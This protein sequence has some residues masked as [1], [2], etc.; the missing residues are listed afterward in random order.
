MAGI[1]KAGAIRE[2][3]VDAPVAAFNL[4]DF[5][6]KADRY[7]EQIRGEA[8]KILQ[9]A[10]AEAQ[11]IRAKAKE[12]GRQQARQ[13]AEKA[14]EAELQRRSETA[15]AT[16]TKVTE[17][18]AAERAQWRQDWET[19][20]VKLARGIAE[21]VIRRELREDPQISLEW[22]REALEMCSRDTQVRIRV[23]LD[24]ARALEPM[25]QALLEKLGR[26]ATTT[27]VPDET[28]PPGEVLLETEHGSLDQRVASQLDRLE[29]ELL[30]E[31]GAA[32]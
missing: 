29:R 5:T 7:L 3:R 32:S 14:L 22:V 17:R 25:L 27:I 1:I 10:Q 28:T 8:T 11:Q 18:L 26:V 9:A 31:E 19:Y 13:E 24:E 21:R 16:L 23:G 2:D 30:G 12:E 20:A 6:Q 4:D 15:M